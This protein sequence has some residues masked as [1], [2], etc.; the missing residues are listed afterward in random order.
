[1]SRTVE[2]SILGVLLVLALPAVLACAY[3]GIATLLSRSIEPP[4]ASS[5]SLCFAVIVPAHDEAPVIARCVASLRK[6]DWPADRFRVIVVAD[7]CHDSTAALARTA[8]ARVL[9][10]RDPNRRGKGYALRFAFCVTCCE[11][12]ADAVVVI[13]ADSEVSGNLLEAFAARIERGAHAIQ[14]HYGVLNPSAGWRTRLLAIAQSAFHIVRSRARER[15]NV[16]CGIRGNGW[17]VTRALLEAVPY[18]AFSI[19]EDV[20]YGIDLGLAGYRVLYAGEAS[21]LA[22]MVCNADSAESQRQRWEG[23][24]CA[25]RRSRMVQLLRTGLRERSAVCID[26][27]LDLLVPPLSQITLLV[28]TLLLVAALA[29][30][31]GAPSVAPLWVA[32]G[33]EAVLLLY[34]LRGWQLSGTGAR[35]LADL[36]HA[37]V[38]VLWKMIVILRHHGSREW[39]RTGRE[40]P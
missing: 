31:W 3:L 13:D 23:G 24:R 19:A 40:Q 30:W 16:S 18:K 37:P 35:G 12:W 25:L 14:A 6:L 5:R 33:C 28:A 20:E 7:N 32:F 39:V 15:L 38:F 17:C 1:V 2:I 22:D 34:V 26:L 27:A 10:R 21:A 29:F 9:Q 11:R 8:G 4:P 36:I